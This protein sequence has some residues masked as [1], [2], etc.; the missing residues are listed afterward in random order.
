MVGK[1]EIHETK[2]KINTKIVGVLI[3]FMEMKGEI[4]ESASIYILEVRGMCSVTVA[5]QLIYGW[6][7][8][9]NE[10]KCL[11]CWI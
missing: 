1:A 7:C 8:E 10:S 4:N 2:F 11:Q 6:K 9:L 3:K 5:V